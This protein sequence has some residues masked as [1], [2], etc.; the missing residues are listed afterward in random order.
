MLPDQKWVTEDD[1]DAIIAR[2]R[3]RELRQPPQFR[4]PDIESPVRD[5]SRSYPLD[6]GSSAPPV[7]RYTIR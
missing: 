1:A 2:R 5:R 3:S 4:L 7:Y 6:Q